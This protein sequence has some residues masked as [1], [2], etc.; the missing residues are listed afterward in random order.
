MGRKLVIA[1][2]KLMVGTVLYLAIILTARFYPRAAGMMLTFPT[3][4]GLTLALAS[5]PSDAAKSARTMLLLPVFNGLLCA[6]Y[7]FSFWLF[8]HDDF[9]A[10]FLFAAVIIIWMAV[11]IPVAR[12]NRGIPERWQLVY[13][14]GCTFAFVAFALIVLAFEPGNVSSVANGAWFHFLVL[15]WWRVGL[16][17]GCLGLVIYVQ[18]SFPQ[19]HGLIGMLGGF[20][21]IPFFG[22]WTLASDPSKSIGER[23]DAFSNMGSSVW[24]GPVVG[25]WF[26]YLFSRYLSARPGLYDREWKWITRILAAG[27]GWVLCGIAIGIQT[28]IMNRVY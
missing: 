17:F 9:S 24:L 15:N 4:N 8:W 10:N 5:T 25:F 13:A 3:L 20:P 14:S 27:V 19:A 18:A 6:F 12:Y 7:I 16:F 2:A 22:V 21:V 11:A 26:I 28:Y 1:I 23:I